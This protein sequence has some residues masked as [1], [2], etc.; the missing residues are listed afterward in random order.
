M[1][2]KLTNAPRYSVKDENWTVEKL[3]QLLLDYDRDV[4]VKYYNDTVKS[5]L[6][7]NSFGMKTQTVDFIST[8]SN[9]CDKTLEFFLY[10]NSCQEIR[11][12]PVTVGLLNDYL[13][14]VEDAQVPV[15]FSDLSDEIQTTLI[16]IQAMADEVAIKEIVL[17]LKKWILL[18]KL[19]LMGGRY[20]R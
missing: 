14:K 8:G 3:K 10:S 5:T 4:I 9:S 17:Y 20:G 19:E 12:A 16:S 11:K 2:T 1:E 6:N 15:V 7:L 18:L 13:D